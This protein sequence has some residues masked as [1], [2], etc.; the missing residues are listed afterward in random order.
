MIGGIDEKGV[1]HPVKA[2]EELPEAERPAGNRR[3][4]DGA[5]IQG[6]AVDQQNQ[7]GETEQKKR[8]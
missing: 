3:A 2:H 1:A 7:R 5:Q 8:P 4:A 6:S